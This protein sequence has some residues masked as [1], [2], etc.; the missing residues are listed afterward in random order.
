[1]ECEKYMELFLKLDR[2]EK[3]SAEMAEHA[4]N[5]PRC[6]AETAA[7]NRFADFCAAYGNIAPNRDLT[8]GI[9]AR[10]A[11]EK[12]TPEEAALPLSMANWIGTGLLLFSGMLLI[13]FSTILQ[14]LVLDMPGLSIALPIVLGSSI[15]IYATLFTGSHIKTLSRFLR[16]H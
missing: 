8:A 4:E 1:M 14:E 13:P 7:F 10:I 15:A 16:L 5:C 9:M 6:A 3:L 2:G 11:W 12:E